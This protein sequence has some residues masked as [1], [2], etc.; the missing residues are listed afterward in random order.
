[1]SLPRS[2]DSRSRLVLQYGEERR[3]VSGTVRGTLGLC[4][5][6]LQCRLQPAPKPTEDRLALLLMFRPPLDLSARFAAAAILWM[7]SVPTSELLG[8]AHDHPSPDCGK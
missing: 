6:L 2:A 7:R 1:M 3:G 5:P 8:S 4:T